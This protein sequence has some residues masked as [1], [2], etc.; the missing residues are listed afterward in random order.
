VSSGPRG[1]PTEVAPTTWARIVLLRA[2]GTEITSWPVRGC[3]P[4]PLAVVDELARWEL[5][6]RRAGGA[7]RLREVSPALAELLELVGLGREV[8]WE[9]EGGEERVGVEE[10]VEGRDPPV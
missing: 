3:G 9:P 10:G 7:I 2:D 4:L 6:A 1:G 5:M 8:G